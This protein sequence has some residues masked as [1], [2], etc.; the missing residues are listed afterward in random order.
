MPWKG[1]KDPYKVWLSEIILQQTRVEQGWDY[2]KKFIQKFP[3]ISALAKTSDEK[4]YKMWEGL[5]Y[6]TRCRNLIHT[7][8]FIAFENDGK[9]PAEYKDILKLKGVGPY[10]AAAIASFAFNQPCAVVDGNVYRVLSRYFGIDVPLD[11]EKSKKHFSLLAHQL[12]DKKNPGIY[13]QALMDFGAIVCKPAAPLCSS[14]PLKKDCIAFRKNIVSELPVKTKK[15]KKRARWMYY[16]LAEYKGKY[17]VSKR[18]KKDIWQNLNEFLLVESGKKISTA[19]VLKKA[20]ASGIVRENG[21]KLIQASPLHIQ[22]LSHQKIFGHFFHIRYHSLPPIP[23]GGRMVSAAALKKLAFPRII[24][25]FL[26][27]QGIR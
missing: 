13:N 22:H 21:Y 24:K 10:T 5:G 18:D 9:F 27:T 11:S 8:R 3:D 4:I 19:A 7:A 16:I 15:P 26:E 17:L 6:Y 20:S 14:C 23:V 2:Y 1:E 12:L 25:S